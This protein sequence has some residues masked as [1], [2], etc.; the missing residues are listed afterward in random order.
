MSDSK[1]T[2]CNEL[3]HLYDIHWFTCFLGQFNGVTLIKPSVAQHVIHVDSCLQGGG[4]LCSGLEYYKVH[5][6]DFL[7]TFGFTISSLECWNLLVAARLWLPALTRH[8]SPG[9]QTLF[10]QFA[11]VYEVDMQSSVLEHFGAFAEFLLTVVGHRPS[12]KIICLL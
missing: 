8:Y 2:S 4:G 3:Y 11:L 1:I 6:P 10:I 9:L 7:Q 12:L 5:Y